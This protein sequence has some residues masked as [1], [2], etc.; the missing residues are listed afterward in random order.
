MSTTASSTPYGEKLQTSKI[1]QSLI[2]FPFI[3]LYNLTFFSSEHQ[4][5]SFTI[6]ILL[7]LGLC[8]LGR[9]HHSP[10]PSYTLEAC[11]V[12]E[13]SQKNNSDQWDMLREISANTV[14]CTVTYSRS[15]EASK[16]IN[17]LAYM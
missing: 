14:P 6:F 7:P 13:V 8:C 2:E 11:S 9:P 17:V 3:W 4:N 15:N 5:F 12:L 1:S 10:H 16:I